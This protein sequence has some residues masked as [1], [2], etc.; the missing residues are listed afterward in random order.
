MLYVPVA[1]SEKYRAKAFIDI[2]VL[3]AAKGVAILFSGVISLWF[4]DFE[5][6]RW[7]SVLVV[8]FVVGWL[9]LIRYLHRAYR[10]REE[11]A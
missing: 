3:R 7:L 9:V 2:F 10:W 6:I 5:D 4:A 11:Q 1:Q 8:V